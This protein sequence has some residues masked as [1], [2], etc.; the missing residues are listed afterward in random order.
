MSLRSV[1][2]THRTS[3]VVTVEAIREVTVDLR[4]SETGD[5]R[6]PWQGSRG[7]LEWAAC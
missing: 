6:I 3:A 1:S 5:A 7:Q 2:V 4:R